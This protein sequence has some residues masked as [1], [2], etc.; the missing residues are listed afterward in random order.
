MTILNI[1]LINGQ[2][3]FGVTRHKLQDNIKMDY[4]TQGM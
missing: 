2:E 1:K 4:V 3:S